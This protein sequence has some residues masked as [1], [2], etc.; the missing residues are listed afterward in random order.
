[1]SYEEK[2]ED[3]KVLFR[4]SQDAPWEEMPV[5]TLWHRY[6]AALDIARRS[7]DTA[8]EI[9]SRLKSRTF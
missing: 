1:M 5:K 7:M 8:D 4:A 9:K 2:L 6:Q 3:D